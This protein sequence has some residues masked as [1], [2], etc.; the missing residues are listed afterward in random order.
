[1][2]GVRQSNEAM[3]PPTHSH[4]TT[5]TPTPHAVTHF[6]TWTSSAFPKSCPKMAN[7]GA[8]SL[9]TGARRELQCSVVAVQYQYTG[10][11]RLDKH[12]RQAGVQCSG[13]AV[14]TGAPSIKKYREERTPLTSANRVPSQC[15]DALLDARHVPHEHEAQHKSHDGLQ[16]GREGG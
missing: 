16:G 9:Y 2:V 13:T 6:H 10:Q 8:T 11:G 3:Y 5:H 4:L 14:I 12:R 7:T 15:G 1:M